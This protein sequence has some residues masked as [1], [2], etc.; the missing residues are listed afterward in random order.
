MDVLKVAI[1]DSKVEAQKNLEAIIAKAEQEK[2]R[3]QEKFSAK[4]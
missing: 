2:L 3:L 4:V 1:E